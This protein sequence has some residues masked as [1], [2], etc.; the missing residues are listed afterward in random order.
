M[1]NVVK[2]YRSATLI[3]SRKGMEDVIKIV[4]SL[5]ESGFEKDC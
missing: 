2:S 4:E 1:K 5:E 3:I